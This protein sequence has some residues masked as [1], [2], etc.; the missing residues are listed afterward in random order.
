MLNTKREVEKMTKIY[1][2][3]KIEAKFN[4]EWSKGG[5]IEL[6][7]EKAEADGMLKTELELGL[8]SNDAFDMDYVWLTENPTIPGACRNFVLGYTQAILEAGI[9]P[10]LPAHMNVWPNKTYAYKRYTFDADEIGAVPW[11]RARTKWVGISP[12]KKNFAREI[13]LKSTCNGDDVSEY[14][15]SSTNVPLSKAIATDTI[16]MTEQQFGEKL[17]FKTPQDVLTFGCEFLKK[18][19]T[20]WVK[21]V[22]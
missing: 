3:S 16:T 6:S 18:H 19:Q 11:S 22:A 8:G 10:K 9:G 2:F 7:A 13:D 1:H 5:D 14:W 12:R 20:K 21:K 15:V 4:G 17:G